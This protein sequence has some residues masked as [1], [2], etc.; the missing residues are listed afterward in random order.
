MNHAR[1]P[2]FR[3]P[4][5]KC[6]PLG[7]AALLLVSAC[8]Q[9]ADDAVDPPT[10]AGA[11]QA[12]ADGADRRVDLPVQ[13]FIIAFHT[14][15]IAADLGAN[16]TYEFPA[17]WL[18]APDGTLHSRITDEAGLEQLRQTFGSLDPAAAPGD[19]LNLDAVAELVAQTGASLDRSGNPEAWTALV[20]L[21]EEAC[22]QP[23]CPAFAETAAQLQQSHPDTLHTI[24][25]TL[26]Q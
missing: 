13:D 18:Y 26:V 5:L 14:A 15:S 9:P 1:R 21:G 4:F 24:I 22:G 17:I 19:G 10:A 8:T 12:A 2:S 20:L 3:A 6:L 7:V 11:S 16:T 23:P 25:V